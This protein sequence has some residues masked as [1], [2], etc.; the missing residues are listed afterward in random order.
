MDSLSSNFQLYWY[1][2]I[3]FICGYK[4]SLPSKY[5]RYWYLKIM[6]CYLLQLP[7][8]FAGTIAILCQM[9]RWHTYIITYKKKL[10]KTEQKE[11]KN[12]L[13][14]SLCFN[15][16]KF[17][18]NSNFLNQSSNC[19]YCIWYVPYQYQAILSKLQHLQSH[20]RFHHF[21]RQRRLVFAL[22]HYLHYPSNINHR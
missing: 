5:Q 21:L 22:I 9:K 20:H 4:D 13:F 3:K 1:E 7:I 2:I 18:L 10:Q 11:L 17:L 8:V 6:M 12:H 15:I 16:V 14:C 19:P